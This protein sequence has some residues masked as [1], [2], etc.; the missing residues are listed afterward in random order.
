M[1]NTV[2]EVGIEDGQIAIVEYKLPAD[3]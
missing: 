2:I 3:K 1:L